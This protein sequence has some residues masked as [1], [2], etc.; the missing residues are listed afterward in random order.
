MDT[1]HAKYPVAFDEFPE[2]V[3]QPYLE[4]QESR[5]R[6]TPKYLAFDPVYKEVAFEPGHKEV[7]FDDVHKE[8]VPGFHLVGSSTPHDATYPGTATGHSDGRNPDGSRSRTIC[9]LAARKFWIVLLLV[10]TVV[11]AAVGGGVGGSIA[12]S[13]AHQGSS[14]ETSAESTSSR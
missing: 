6:E 8:A 5:P 2:V 10:A 14:N 1:N 11:A 9:G 7:V 12:A 13:R 4:D 3:E